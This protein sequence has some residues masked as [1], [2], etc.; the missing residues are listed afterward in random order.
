[1]GQLLLLPDARPLDQRL[2]TRFFRDAPRRPGVYLMKDAAGKVLYVGKAKNLKARLNHYRVANPERMPRRHLRLVREVASIEFEFCANEAAALA[3]EA[4]L[5]R[6]LKP[7]FNR[8]GVWPGRSV[9]IAW[10]AVEHHVEMSVVATPEPGWRRFGP[11]GGGARYAHR[12]LARL[13]WLAVHPERA[14]AELPAGWA[15]GDRMER[16]AIPC[17]PAIAEVMELL[18]R[19][20]WEVPEPFVGWLGA[21]L[22]AR[23]AGFER[24]AIATELE[25]LKSFAEL[26][27]QPAHHRQQLAL[28]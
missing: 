10:R 12:A 20:F 28:L 14:L 13:L 26:Q 25:T 16:T 4:K 6:T 15:H 9:F 23:T 7:K 8:A 21:R 24:A 22:S 17:G 27:N 5:L 11:L 2:G 1:M 19:F 3:H 18:D